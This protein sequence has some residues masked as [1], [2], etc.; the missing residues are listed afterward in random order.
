MEGK[1][2]VAIGPTTGST[3]RRNGFEPLIPARYT[4]KDAVELAARSSG[5]S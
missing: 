3:M 5:G 2:L 1:R 4:V